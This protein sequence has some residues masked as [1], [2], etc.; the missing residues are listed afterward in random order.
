MMH[1]FKNE[2][3]DLLSY[4]PLFMQ[5]YREIKDIME[6]ENP[7]FNLLWQKLKEVFGNQFIEYCN[8]NGISK[9][10]DMLGLHHYE[11][12]TLEMR[13]FR[14][15]VAWNDNIPYTW[16][17]LVNKMDQLCGVGNYELELDNNRYILHVTTRFDDEKKYDELNNMLN[18][19]KPANLGVD[20]INV[21]TPKSENDI[22]ITNGLVGYMKY[23]I[24]AKL[25]DTI[26]KILATT[27]VIH[28]KKYTI[29]G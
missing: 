3:V 26:F 18:I 23:E 19:I 11:N 15:L 9:F 16:R 21:L 7:E 17:V 4:L 29:G 2:N 10:E 13:I 5:E 24:N 25:P 8:E 20:S 28:G 12:D 22:Y 6:S 1:I 27:G 14:V